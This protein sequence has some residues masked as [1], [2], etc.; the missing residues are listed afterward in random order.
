LSDLPI[1]ADAG[2]LI[3][4][5]RVGLVD[6][7]RQLYKKVLIPDQVLQE[8]RISDDRPGSR[9][10]HLATKD[11]W[12]GTASIAQTEELSSLCLALDPGEAAAILLAAQQSCR[13][14][15]L[16]ERRGRAIAKSRGVRVVGTGGV[17]LIAK[18]QGLLQNLSAVLDRLA[19][20]GY[21]LSQAL[22]QE[23][24]TLAGEGSE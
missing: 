22:R 19:E 10:L 11:G 20:N 9:L 15:L 24:L 1:V 18:Q 6:L 8:L 16:D 12:L 13:F 2:P 17:L 3:G 5:A 7:L 23:I 14:L 4:L 21:R